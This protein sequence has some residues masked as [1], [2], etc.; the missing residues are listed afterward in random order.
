MLLAIDIGNSSITVGFVSFIDKDNHEIMFSFKIS[1]KNYSSDEYMFII[2]S[3]AA[4]HGLCFAFAGLRCADSDPIDSAVISSV[5]PALTDILSK[6]AH[7]LC[8]KPPF[9]I[10]NGIR[11]GFGIKIRNPEQLGSDIVSNVASAFRL[12]NPPFV[13]LDMG[14]ATTLTIVDKNSDILG[15][16]IIPGLNVAMNALSESAAL[17]SDIDL[18]KNEELIGRDTRSA[19][20]SGVMNGNIIMLDG[21]IR[22]IRDELNLEETKDKLGLVATGGLAE[23]IIP[24]MRNKFIFQETLTLS[25]A[26]YLYRKNQ[27][28]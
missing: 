17:L 24:Y 23:K 2:E 1:N 12:V 4:R 20:S 11:T 9:I 25:G 10:S 13:V 5:V 14:T 26:V 6:S 7:T 21:F 16:I 28:K 15:T 19:I 3:F 18:K 22:N 27:Q 8:G